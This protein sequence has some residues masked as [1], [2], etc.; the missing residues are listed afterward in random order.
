MHSSNRW[1]SATRWPSNPLLARELAETDLE[2]C[3]ILAASNQWSGKLH[4]VWFAAQG[5]LERLRREAEAGREA[6]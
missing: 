6:K 2:F 5:T 3:A 1:H 4:D